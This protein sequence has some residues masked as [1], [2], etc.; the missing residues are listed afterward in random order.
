MTRRSIA[1]AVVGVGD[2]SAASGEGAVVRE[3]LRVLAGGS[4]LVAIA[5]GEVGAVSGAAAGASCAGGEIGGA[6]VASGAG[7][8]RRK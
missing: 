5:G 6:L 2:S 8:G 7:D 4:L 3:V 1:G